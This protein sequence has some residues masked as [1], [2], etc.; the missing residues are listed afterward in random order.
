MSNFNWTPL[1]QS[2]Y[3]AQLF[4]VIVNAEESGEPDPLPYLDSKGI[5]TIGIGFSLRV[6]AISKAILIF[7]LALIACNPA[8]SKEVTKDQKSVEKQVIEQAEKDTIVMDKS[9]YLKICRDMHEILNLPEN[10]GYLISNYTLDMSPYRA[11][12]KIPASYKDFKSVKWQKSS[13]EEFKKSAPK[14]YQEM[15]DN[16]RV[17]KNMIVEKTILNID[18]KKE[19]RL[20]FKIRPNSGVDFNTM[21]MDETIPDDITKSFNDSASVTHE[22]E[23]IYYQGLVYFVSPAPV[24]LAILDPKIFRD[25]K[26]RFYVESIC[27]Y[28]AE[29]QSK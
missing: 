29:E 16:Q 22:I 4:Q 7:T 24:G 25:Y 9:S 3:D 28:R 6:G 14:R 5:P 11:L 27:Q 8:F 1:S 26:P 20:I 18:H 12:P 10:K 23:V 2:E 15:I 19:K 21:Y 13:V 17:R